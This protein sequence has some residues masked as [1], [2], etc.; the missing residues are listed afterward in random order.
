MH[1]KA[2]FAVTDVQ[3]LP[4]LKSHDE[5]INSALELIKQQEKAALELQKQLKAAQDLFDAAKLK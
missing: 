5:Q 2:D 1:D 4:A 3:L